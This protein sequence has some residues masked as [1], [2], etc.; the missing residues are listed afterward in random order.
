MRDSAALCTQQ[1]DLLIA[2]TERRRKGH[3]LILPHL[4]DDLVERLL[5]GL[6]AAAGESVRVR[7]LRPAS[8]SSADASVHWHADAWGALP[9][10]ARK[11]GAVAAGTTAA[12]LR[13]ISADI[14]FV[15]SPPPLVDVGPKQVLRL[16]RSKDPESKAV[17]AGLVNRQ[18]RVLLPHAEKLNDGLALSAAKLATALRKIKLVRI[19]RLPEVAT[20][21][22]GIL[23]LDPSIATREADELLRSRREE[24]AL[25]DLPEKEAGQLLALNQTDAALWDLATNERQGGSQ[26]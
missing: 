11:G 25:D 12:Q 7:V 17:L 6:L 19:D 24:N 4:D 10:P 1:G 18:S 9:D 20:E 5:K 23:D 26:S 2:W 22:A 14:M 21:L 15:V 13:G 16:L 8:P 3:S